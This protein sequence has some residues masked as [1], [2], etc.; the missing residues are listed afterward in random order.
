M[1]EKKL[2]VVGILVAVGLFTGAGIISIM[3]HPGTA[4]TECIIQNVKKYF[5]CE[6][7]NRMFSLLNDK[8]PMPENF[9]ARKNLLVNRFLQFEPEKWPKQ[10]WI[11]P[12]WYAEFDSHFVPSLEK[13]V[14]WS[15]THKGW[16][17]V[18]CVG[19]Y[20]A[21][22]YVKVIN[23]TK[24]GHEFDVWTWVRSP[25]GMYKNQGIGLH[26]IYPEREEFEE[27]GFDLGENVYVQNPAETERYIS[28][29]MSPDE[30][31]LGPSWPVFCI[32]NETYKLGNRDIT[33]QED[34]VRMIKTHVKISG[35]TPPGRYVV[36]WNAYNPSMQFSDENYYKYGFDYTDPN[37]GE[38]SC[39]PREYRLF[40]E[41]E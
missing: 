20:P 3:S 32:R 2:A 17:P 22:Y 19:V 27:R 24:A 10:Y 1:D 18:W 40:V 26:T 23:L 34:Y 13:Y 25:S 31:M 35:D 14:E 41:I 37:K 6:Y 16:V 21:D 11:W 33:C 8:Y 9:E 15:K 29:Q 7:Q 38:F 5:D 30:F 12:Q 4:E 36:G 28:I 39:G